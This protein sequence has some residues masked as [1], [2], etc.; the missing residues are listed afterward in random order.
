MAFDP[1]AFELGLDC[2]LNRQQQ[3]PEDFVWSEYGKSVG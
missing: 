2:D 1:R 3:P